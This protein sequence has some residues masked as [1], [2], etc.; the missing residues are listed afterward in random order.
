MWGTFHIKKWPTM[1]EYGALFFPNIPLKKMTCSFKYFLSK[2]Q[3]KI[4]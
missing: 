2:A 1:M 4:Q 3:K